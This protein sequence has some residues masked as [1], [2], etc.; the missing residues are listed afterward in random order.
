MEDNPASLS[1]LVDLGMLTRAACHEMNNLLASQQGFLRMLDRLPEQDANQTRWLQQVLTVSQEMALLV[2]SL[3]SRAHHGADPSP[4]SPGWQEGSAV[5]A[6]ASQLQR[7]RVALPTL[8]VQRLVALLGE[9]CGQDD[10]SLRAVTR[11]HTRDNIPQGGQA[12]FGYFADFS[13]AVWLTVSDRSD[14]RALQAL[15][16]STESILPG[17]DAQE[18][19]WLAALLSALLRQHG[20]DVLVGKP[21]ETG[22]LPLLLALPGLPAPEI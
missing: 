3:Q 22:N 17:V 13:N 14:G 2:R 19:D 21:D 16:G 7:E 8:I 18:V 10:H 12:L 9:L 15:L 1:A 5:Q 11:I 6:I 20:G 4:L